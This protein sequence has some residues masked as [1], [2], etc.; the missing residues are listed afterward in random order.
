MS[1]GL[2]GELTDISSENQDLLDLASWGLSPTRTCLFSPVSG[3]ASLVSM[4]TRFPVLV[5]SWMRYLLNAEASGQKLGV[6]TGSGAVHFNC[7]PDAS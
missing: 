2:G 3:R 4:A 6:E 7:F 1:R 5:F